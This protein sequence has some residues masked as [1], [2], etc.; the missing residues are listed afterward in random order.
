[1]FPVYRY[2]NQGRNNTNLK[3]GEEEEDEARLATTGLKQTNY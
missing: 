3:R 1:M 2:Y